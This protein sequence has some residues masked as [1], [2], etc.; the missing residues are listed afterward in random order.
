MSA[1]PSDKMSDS[2]TQSGKA[3]SSFPRTT[4]IVGVGIGGLIIGIVI[5]WL[6]IGW[7]LWPVEYVG[8]AYTYELSLPDKVNYVAALTDSYSLRRQIDLIHRQLLNWPLEDKVMAFAELYAQYERDGM[9]VEARQV[10]ELAGQLK[11]VEGWDASL[12]NTALSNLVARYFEKG[13]REHAKFISLFGD[14]LGLIPVSS[15]EE[16]VIP[17]SQ[18]PAAV[19]AVI[20]TQWPI[21][22]VVMI[23]FVVLAAFGVY[24]LKIRRVRGVP[25]LM[26]GGTESS[27]VAPS[28]PGT[29]LSARSVYELGMDNFDE[30][31][32]IEEGG[33]FKGECGMGISE[34]IGQD[35]PRKVTALEIWLFDKGDIRTITKVLA[36]EYAYQEDVLRNRLSARGETF[37]V[38]PGMTFALETA[39]LALKATVLDVEYGEST[40]VPPR[41]FFKKVS[42]ALSVRPRA[43]IM[44]E[45]VSPEEGVSPLDESAEQ[46]TNAREQ[47]LEDRT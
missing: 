14:E 13:D 24:W 39:K 2:T 36:S 30:S 3:S 27:W 8:E 47:E 18:S 10:V 43:T 35:R 26:R 11:Q 1:Q 17:T 32:S 25:G 46:E 16:V 21:I 45:E 42:V 40:D 20:A 28:E 12:V 33:V 4:L 6:A 31:F 7:L 37:L 29:L 9:A 41:S 44:E 23:V 38:Q 5:G 15:G 19:S 34:T 22:L